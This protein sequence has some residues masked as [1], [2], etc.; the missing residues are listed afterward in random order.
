MDSNGNDELMP[1]W[2]VCRLRKWILSAGG[3][4]AH[5]LQTR[6]PET[7][8]MIWCRVVVERRRARF[9]NIHQARGSQKSGRS[10]SEHLALCLFV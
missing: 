2:S 1:L 3:A 5:F 6:F 8:E 10:E 7:L 4:L 9:N